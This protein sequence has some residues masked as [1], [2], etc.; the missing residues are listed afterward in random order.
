MYS[1]GMDTDTSKMGWSE[2]IRASALAAAA[3]TLGPGV[4]PSAVLRVAKKYESYL[5][6]GKT[7]E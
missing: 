7:S 5:L 6:S 1:G 3:R 2:Q 4:T